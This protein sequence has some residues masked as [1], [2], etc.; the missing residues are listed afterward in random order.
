VEASRKAITQ[1]VAHSIAPINFDFRDQIQFA[2]CMTRQFAFGENWTN[3]SS[4]IDNTRVAAAQQG[5]LRLISAEAWRGAWFLDIGCGSGLSSL[6]AGRLGVA[7]IHAID[8]DPKCVAT[9]RSVLTSA[10][11][12]KTPWNADVMDV[13]DLDP[14][15]HGRFDIVY[16]WGVLHHTGEMWAALR[17]SAAMVKPGGWLAIALYRKTR[18]DGFWRIEKRCYAFAPKPVQ[19]TMRV[20][21]V[22][23]LRSKNLM[24]GKATQAPGRGM[25]FTH[26][27][28]D[29]L[30]GFPYETASATEVD[31]F[32]VGLGFVAERIFARPISLGLFGSDCNEYVYRR[33]G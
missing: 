31:E 12:L 17:H 25:D 6:A 19:A 5:L 29:W 27:V 28:H 21:Y 22:A 9:T 14:D 33:T 24:L 32:L 8:I 30:G 20:A 1:R 10:Q 2:D 13:S 16:S 7:R 23:A 3:F 18:L 15:R 4:L 26:D 11:D